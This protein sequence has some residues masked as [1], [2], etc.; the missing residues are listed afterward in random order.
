ML[1]LSCR[2]VTGLFN[3]HRRLETEAL[4][5]LTFTIVKGFLFIRL[6]LDHAILELSVFPLHL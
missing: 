2:D 6:D 5:N 3:I 1:L 4:D